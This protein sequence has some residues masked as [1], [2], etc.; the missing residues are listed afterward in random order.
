VGRFVDENEGKSE[1]QLCERER[2]IAVMQLGELESLSCSLP[3]GKYLCVMCL[4]P[5][6]HKI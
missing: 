4:F 5:L 1:C 3:G 2:F 6:F